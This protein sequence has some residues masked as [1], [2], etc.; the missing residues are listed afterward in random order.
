MKKAAFLFAAIIA[1]VAVS[2]Y[3]IE[4][5]ITVKDDGSLTVEYELLLHSASKETGDFIKNRFEKAPGVQLKNFKNKDDRLFTF[6]LECDN[7]SS[8]A[9]ACKDLK[10]DPFRHDNMTLEKDKNGNWKFRLF[11]K[12]QTAQAQSE[13]SLPP[14]IVLSIKL[15]GELDNTNAHKT[16]DNRATWT[17]AGA[18]LGH[19][20][21]FATSKPSRKKEEKHH[22]ETKKDTDKKEPEKKTDAKKDPQTDPARQA[23]E[24]FIKALRAGDRDTVVLL[25]GP[26]SGNKYE[27]TLKKFHEELTKSKE[28][29]RLIDDFKKITEVKYKSKTV[30]AEREGEWHI[31]TFEVVNEGE[32]EDI[33]L[34]LLELEPGKWLVCDID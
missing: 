4:E 10:N 16:K 29:D 33:A 28:P 30:D 19:M 18:R 27:G 8:L 11:H 9:S 2:C 32:T 31:V 20:K 26:R 25:S 3:E 14:E 6:T 17:F 21:M 34:C 15:P 7:V 5:T 1:L 22:K 24:L 13:F 12:D 23:A